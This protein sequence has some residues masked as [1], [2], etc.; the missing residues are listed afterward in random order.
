[1]FCFCFF[2]IAST[3]LYLYVWLADPGFVIVSLDKELAPTVAGPE[4]LGS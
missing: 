1:M 2:F 4:S 3:A